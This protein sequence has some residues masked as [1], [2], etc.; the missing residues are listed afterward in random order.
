M[1][2]YPKAN[3]KHHKLTLVVICL[4]LTNTHRLRLII[5]ALNAAF[6]SNSLWQRR[7]NVVGVPHPHHIIPQYNRAQAQIMN[8]IPYTGTRIIRT[9]IIE[10]TDERCHISFTHFNSSSYLMYEDAT[11]RRNAA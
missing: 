11:Q 3:N 2:A 6:K 5:I 10:T 7:F 9:H 1:Q 8:R 4:T